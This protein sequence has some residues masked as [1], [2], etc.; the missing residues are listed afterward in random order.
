MCVNVHSCYVMY[1]G[2]RIITGSYFSP[3]TT[4]SGD[5]IPV[6]KFTWQTFLPTE[7]PYVHSNFFLF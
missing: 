7:A 4:V 6:V 2:Q 3:F 1:E 5:D